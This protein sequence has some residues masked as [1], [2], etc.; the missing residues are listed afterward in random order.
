MHV[1]NLAIFYWLSNVWI[2]NEFRNNFVVDIEASFGIETID[3]TN[4]IYHTSID[5]AVI[6]IRNLQGEDGKPL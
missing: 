1:M 5:H 6:F 3:P 4:L 2:I